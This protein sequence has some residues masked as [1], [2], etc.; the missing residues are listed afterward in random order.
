[1]KFL[2]KLYWNLMSKYVLFLL[3][4]VVI[5][6]VYIAS[7]LFIIM[8]SLKNYPELQEM[9]FMPFDTLI[10]DDVKSELKVSPQ[11]ATNEAIE[12]LEDGKVIYRIGKIEESK[13]VYTSKQLT[14]ITKGAT[15]LRDSKIISELFFIEGTSG[16]NYI[17]LF[18]K[19]KTTNWHINYGLEES[20]IG[21]NEVIKAVNNRL[22]LA[23]IGFIIGLLGIIILFSRITSKK[24]MKPLRQL[25][26]GLTRVDNGDY[27]FRMIYKGQTEFENISNKFNDMAK[28]LQESELENKRLSDS[29]KQL[30]LN[31]SHDLRTPATTVLGYAEALE[32]GL[33]EDEIQKQKY[34]SYIRV[35]A[36]RITELIAKLFK[37]SK[38]EN[39]VYDLNMEIVDFNEFV[40]SIVINHYGEIE[41]KGFALE[42]DIPD[43]ENKILIDKIELERAFSNI[44]E[45]AVKYNEAG[46]TISIKVETVDNDIK[47]EIQDNGVGIPDQ[48]RKTIFQSLV[49]GDNSRAT[50]GGLGLGM[51][52]TKKIIEL[53]GGSISLEEKNEN[54]TKFLILLKNVKK[55]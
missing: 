45:N 18:H 6:V 31:I 37:Y 47:V 40:R 51:S 34:Y 23:F 53:H 7:L 36:E 52:I 12:I 13:E 15:V 43:K 29:K 55:M 17:L 26:E 8:L 2:K 22:V 20:K 19:P 9:E 30:L 24:I 39:S 32:N 1:M 4:T 5:T 46:T 41:Q 21:N 3:M 54:G 14:E 27:E 33:V 48:I 42:L 44:I 49:R 28:R 38:L 25:D 35:K 50:D 10:Y 16:K 11:I